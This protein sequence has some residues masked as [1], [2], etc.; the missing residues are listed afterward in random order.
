MTDMTTRLHTLLHSDCSR[1][2]SASGTSARFPRLVGHPSHC[3]TQNVASPGINNSSVDLDKPSLVQHAQ[4]S[5][6]SSAFPLQT[7]STTVV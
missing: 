7:R 2:T 3:N 6:M 4:V 5:P 1:G